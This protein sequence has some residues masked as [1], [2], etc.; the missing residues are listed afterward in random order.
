MAAG[1]HGGAA[2]RARVG[3]RARVGGGHRPARG[4]LESVARATDYVRRQLEADGL[5]LESIPVGTV[6]APDIVVGGNVVIASRTISVPDHTVLVRLPDDRGATT[7]AI[8]LMAHVDTVEGSPGAVD[9]GVAVGVLLELVRAL[10]QAPSRP[11]PIMVAFTAAEEPGLGGARALAQTLAPGEVAFAVSLDLVGAAG[12]LAFN[13]L[14]RALGLPW[15]ER[16]SRAAAQAGIAVEAPLTHQV[17]SRVLPQL[18]RSDHGAFTERGVPAMHIFHRGPGQIYLEYH[19]PA[20]TLAHVDVTSQRAALA[21]LWALAMDPEPLPQ[22][23]GAGATFL[24]V[25]GATLVRNTV[26][27]LAELAALV[28]VVFALHAA[29]RRPGPTAG[30]WRGALAFAGALLGAWLLEAAVE[31]TV[32]AA[33]GHSQPWIHAPGRNAMMMVLATAALLT[34]ACKPWLHEGR[35]RAALPI[36]MLLAA[37]PGAVLLWFEIVELAWVPLVMALAI[38][39][40]G[41]CDTGTRRALALGVALL[42]AWAVL[43]PL[44]LREA[45]FHG[46][47]GKGVP[48]SLLLAVVLLPCAWAWLHVL[49]AWRPSPALRRGALILAGALWL[50]QLLG[51]L[52]LPPRCSG[53]AWSRRGLACEQPAE[54]AAGVAT[55]P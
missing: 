41:R 4:G 49:A 6:V 5:E 24:P 48:L 17:V 37:L 36:A 52:L 28:V 13:G 31:W 3:T 50:L 44:R 23:P 29:R 45:S 18:E 30:R 33:R 47:L 14:S 19:S 26:L 55:T 20:D 27:W 35:A 10:A 39:A 53:E 21:W 43:D 25:A 9:N 15:L 32:A 34:A 22:G 7:P 51:G 42:P 8:L 40:L 2:A 1:G 11:H 16:L 38:A 46:F 54:A 12:P